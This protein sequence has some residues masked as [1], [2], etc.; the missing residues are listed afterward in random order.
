MVTQLASHAAE[1]AEE[2]IEGVLQYGWVPSVTELVAGG[3]FEELNV[4]AQAV[5]LLVQRAIGTSCTHTWLQ[6]DYQ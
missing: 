1:E 4:K 3:C 2:M 6:I 5:L